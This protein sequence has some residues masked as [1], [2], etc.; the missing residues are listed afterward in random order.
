MLYSWCFMK[1]HL[2]KK[3]NIYLSKKKHL[4][5]IS[6]PKKDFNANKNRRLNDSEISFYLV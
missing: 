4:V 2:W 3:L 5:L 1:N 6:K